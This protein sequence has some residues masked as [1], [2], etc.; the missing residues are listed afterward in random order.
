M[1]AMLGRVF[2]LPSDWIDRL[3]T[4]TR[5]QLASTTYLCGRSRCNGGTNKSMDGK[6]ILAEN[7]MPF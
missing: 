5:P 4:S 7:P 6:L 3:D 1:P 2:A